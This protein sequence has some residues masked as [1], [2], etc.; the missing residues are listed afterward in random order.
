[1]VAQGKI[2]GYT[3]CC[4][5][6]LKTLS[7]RSIRVW[8]KNGNSGYLNPSNQLRWF[9][10]MMN[11]VDATAD[12]FSLPLYQSFW[13]IFW[14]NAAEKYSERPC[15]GDIGST[16][17][18]IGRR[19]GRIPLISPSLRPCRRYSKFAKTKSNAIVRHGR[20][21]F[22]LYLC[23]MYVHHTSSQSKAWPAPTDWQNWQRQRIAHARTHSR[24]ATVIFTIT[25]RAT[26]CDARRFSATEPNQKCTC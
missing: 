11:T 22:A 5:A 9:V 20:T 6:T 1:M 14:I 10:L 7:L 12:W 13:T 2:F 18:T 24:T 21:I 16:L 17:R 15:Y 25:D 23:V 3:T 8:K 26:S 4:L 19:G